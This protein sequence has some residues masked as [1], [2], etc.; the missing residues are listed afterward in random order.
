[1]TAG[2]LRG[3]RIL[4]IAGLGPGPFC[5]M[6]LADHGAEVIR[7]DKPKGTTPGASDREARSV[8]N[9]SR[10]GI[11]LDLKT[12]AG[13]EILRDLARGVDGLIEGFRPGVMERLGLGPEVL[14]NDNPK[15]VYGRM[16]GWGQT[17]PLASRAGHDINYLALSGVLDLLGRAETK[18]TPPIN[19]LADFGGGG[20]LLAFGMVSAILHARMGGAG[21]VLDCSMVEGSALLSSMVWG[22]IAQG[23]W[24]GER[25]HNFLDTGAHFYEVY[26]C[27]DGRHIAIGALEPGFYAELRRVLNL[28][29]DADFDAQSDE[30]GWSALKVKLAALFKTRTRE[31]WCGAFAGRDAC[32]A[33]VL[34]PLEAAV[35]P[36]NAARRSFIRVD[37]VVQ[38]AP[39]PR[40][41]MTPTNT[42]CM[43][44]DPAQDGAE[45]LREL[46]YAEPRIAELKAA[47][48]VG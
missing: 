48:V 32:F 34:S 27:A 47:G 2:P 4:E 20:M 21:Q 26:E 6:M 25:G 39:A 14:L 7:V 15:L 40:W 37:G 28:T 43:L 24:R 18:P 41:S 19:L 13:V 29:D 10:R 11:V 22:F 5:G 16:T 46:G 35:H 44:K 30:S 45:L 12:A 42:P 33:P 1:M 9:R 38:P 23:R 31:E 36:H 3:V 8:L 17:G